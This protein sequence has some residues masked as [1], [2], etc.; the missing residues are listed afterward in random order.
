MIHLSIQLASSLQVRLGDPLDQSIT[1]S[2]ICFTA[3]P[4]VDIVLMCGFWDSSFK[5]F[6]TDTGN[7]LY[8]SAWEIVMVTFHVPWPH[9]Y[10]IYNFGILVC[11]LYLLTF[12][13][14][15]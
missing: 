9:T 11:F 14:I 15:N 6:S 5:T 13:R 12:R 7:L 10:V 3:T 2:S 1:T 4:S 8:H